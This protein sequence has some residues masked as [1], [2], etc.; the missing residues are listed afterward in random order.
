MTQDNLLLD[1]D[2]LSMIIHPLQ[3]DDASLTVSSFTTSVDSLRKV[4]GKLRCRDMRIIS[5]TSNSPVTLTVADAMPEVPSLG[6]LLN[7]LKDFKETGEIPLAWGRSVIDAQELVSLFSFCS[8]RHANGF[9]VTALFLNIRAFIAI[10]TAKIA[11]N[12]IPHAIYAVPS[13]VRVIV[14]STRPC[15]LTCASPH[16]Y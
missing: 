13:V 9:S 7:G 3:G 14:I 6:M 8:G 15:P 5:L 2:K 11:A 16:P 12:K 10:I 1:H 4:A